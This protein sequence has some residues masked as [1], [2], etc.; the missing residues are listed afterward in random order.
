MDSFSWRGTVFF[1]VV[2]FFLNTSTKPNHCGSHRRGFVS[3]K[4]LGEVVEDGEVDERLLDHPQQ[5]AVKQN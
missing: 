2:A 1:P 4:V 3:T 5:Q